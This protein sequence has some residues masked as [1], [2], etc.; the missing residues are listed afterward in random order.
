ME[1]RPL[2]QS[3][4]VD[5]II[6]AIARVTGR[7]VTGKNTNWFLSQLTKR[8]AALPTR[9]L[10]AVLFR[11]NF[12]M[13][14]R[15]ELLGFEIRYLGARAIRLVKVSAELPWTLKDPNWFCQDVTGHLASES[16]IVNGKKHLRIEYFANNTAP[17][18]QQ[19]GGGWRP[20]VAH[21]SPSEKPTFLYQLRFALNP[22]I[23]PGQ[24]DEV[25]RCQVFA[26]DGVSE[27][28]EYRFGDIEKRSDFRL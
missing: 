26:E 14:H 5:E 6:A 4:V 22:D 19:S 12:N 15:Y 13:G 3:S 7:V 11:F 18:R 23:G 20:L 25:I 27:A 9:E 2:S 21:L 1:L 28:F 8:E 10:R 16:S 24:Q 17:D